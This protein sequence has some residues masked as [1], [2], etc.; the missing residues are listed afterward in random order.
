LRF[1]AG[2]LD[3]DTALAIVSRKLG[4]QVSAVFMPFAEAAIDVDKP[5]DKELVEIILAKRD[6]P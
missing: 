3:L 6:N 1:L 5:A 2:T 4:L